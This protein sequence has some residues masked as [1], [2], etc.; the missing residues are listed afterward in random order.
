MGILLGLATALSWGSAD[1]C[2]R[3]STRRIGTFRTMLFMQLCGFIL[4]TLLM[5]I[6]LGGG[7]GHLTDGSGMRPWFWGILAGC[8]NTSSTLA[9]YRSFE[10]GKMSIVAPVSASY[11]V[12]TMLLSVL[13]GEQLT[14]V[15][16]AGMALATSGVVL[17]AGGESIPG[18]V[19]S[20]DDGTQSQKKNLGIGWALYSALGFG[21]MFWLLG[22][23]IVPVVG[24]VQT[25]WLVRLTSVVGTALVMLVAGKPMTLPAKQ[26]V[27]WILG[28]G[29][30]DTG[31]YVLNNWG[32]RLEQISVVSVLA[33]LYGAV[34]VGLA[35]LVLKERVS[36]LQ[37]LGIA[38]IFLGII[39]ISR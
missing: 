5:G 18:D 28:I 11:P 14:A 6:G 21:I 36:K 22:I 38:A 15:R 32:M 30:L 34:T 12:L 37:W 35:A 23:R 29:V 9:L 8:L 39:L 20:I 24:A 27:H 7:W 26:D 13:T 10:I 31:A 2:A 17:V 3:F 1:F 16:L 19:N 33:S 25:V 4:L